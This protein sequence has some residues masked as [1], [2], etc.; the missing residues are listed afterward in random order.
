MTGYEG[1]GRKR[2]Q[3]N[4]QVLIWRT[5]CM[6]VIYLDRE[7]TQKQEEVQEHR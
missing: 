7:G 3:E 1:Y 4:T 2:S 6:E 5:E